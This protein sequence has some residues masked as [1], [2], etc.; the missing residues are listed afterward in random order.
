VSKAFVI[1]LI[2]IICLSLT[3]AGEDLYKVSVFSQ[4]DADKLAETG[5][6]PIL[7]IKNGYLVLADSKQ[8]D[9][10]NKG[11]FRAEFIAED[12]TAQS[13]ALDNRRDDKNVQRFEL[14]YEVDGLRLFRVDGSKSMATDDGSSLVPIHNDN[15]VFRYREP[16]GLNTAAVFQADDLLG[17]IDHVSQ[18][19]VWTYLHVLQAFDGRVAGTSGN[20]AARNWLRDQFLSYGYTNVTLESFWAYVY[21]GTKQCF[22]VVARKTGTEFPDRQI[23]VGAHFDAVPGSPGADDNG[24]GSVG[25]LEIARALADVDTK[26]SFVFILFDSEEQGLNGAWNYANAAASRGDNI[27]CM[28]NMDMIGNLPNNYYADVKYGPDYA[29]AELW[30]ALSDSLVNITGYMAGSASNS[31]HHAFVQNGYDVLFAAEHEFSGVYHTPRD[32]TTYVNFN[33]CTRMIKATLA[34]GYTINLSPLPVRI[35]SIRD[36]GDG[37]SLQVDWQTGDASD[38]D[39]YRV[40]YHAEPSGTLD[41]L[42]VAAGNTNVLINGLT[43]GQEYRIYVIGYNADGYSSIVR[44]EKLGTPYTLP[45]MPQDYRALPQYRAI[46]LAWKADNTE[47]DFSHYAIIRDG[48]ALPYVVTDT[49]FLDNDFF[50]GGDFHDY[51]IVAVDN[52]SNISDTTGAEPIR[53]RAATLEPGKILAVNRS[54]RSSPYVVNEI[55]TGE[56]M[57]DALDGYD[58]IYLSDT[59][60]SSGTDTHSVNLEDMLDYEVMILG[61]ESARTDDFANDPIFGGILDTIGYYLSIGG[62]VIMFGRW[63]DISTG[64]VADTFTVPATGYTSGYRNYFHINKRVKYLSTYTTTLLNSDLVGAHSQAAG[65]PDLVWDSLATVNH[66]APWVEVSGIPC[67][68]FAV[69]TGGQSEILYTYDSRNNIPLTEGK[70]VAWRYSGED[71]QYVYFEI[72]LSFFDRNTAKTVLQTA[73]AG[74]LSSGPAAASAIDPDTLDNSGS[75]PPTVTVYLGDFSDLK[76][77]GDVDQSSIVINGSLSP[78][79]VTVISSHPDFIGE[80][81]EITIPT[82]DFMDTYGTIIDTLSK[83]YTVLWKYTSEPQTKIVYGEITLIGQ[84]YLPGDANGDWAINVADAVY[85]INYVFKGGPPPD[86]I[87]AGDA[88]CDGNPDIGD[89]VFLINYIFKGGLAPGCD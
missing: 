26:M 44:T 37:Q 18:D 22:N 53:M 51:M 52:N 69:L 83:V 79:A 19:S 31:D 45:A 50:L 74:L 17:L 63:G 78:Q 86:P 4:A 75:L 46:H 13:L 56:F 16:L 3:A 39:H 66:S 8:S 33:Y 12:V 77:A 10:L 41:S 28:L 82:A 21:N 67:P 89:A 14:V 72:P 88:N 34:A 85:L 5:V 65:Y 29:Y 80:V 27:V 87:E 30:A 25:V 7:I 11:G 76:T 2:S 35:T 15:M 49:F 64:K 73:L 70:P 20:Y 84:V 71:F 60:S 81:L 1:G 68:S 61:G 6:E 38:I 59:S 9:L 36:G 24:T 58:F 57:R 47:L 48:A 54:N 62:K 40:Y 55:V 42:I 32:S 43:E 23:V